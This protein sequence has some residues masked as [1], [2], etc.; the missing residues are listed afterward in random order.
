MN[1]S[2]RYE[3]RLTAEALEHLKAI[4]RKHR[5][6]I[7]HKLEEQLSVEPL[8][9][10]RNR[11]PLAGST[12]FGPETWELRFGPDNRFR[13]FYRVEA[14]TVSVKGVGVKEGNRLF[15]GGE[16]VCL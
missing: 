1:L 14:E 7:F 12:V 16:E 4:D 8:L 6:A 15:I 11:K 9:R 5:S 3:I 2:P 10:T 13:V